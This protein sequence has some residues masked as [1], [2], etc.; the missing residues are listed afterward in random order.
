[1]GPGTAVAR[2]IMSEISS[3]VNSPMDR[4]SDSMTPSMTMPPPMVKAPILKKRTKMDHKRRMKD[5]AP[6]ER[7]G[8]KSPPLQYHQAATQPSVRGSVPPARVPKEVLAMISPRPKGVGSSII[9]TSWPRD[10]RDKAMSA[11][12]PRS[13]C[14]VRPSIHC[15]RGASSASCGFIPKSTRFETTCRCPWGCMKAPITPNG[16]TGWQRDRKSV[17]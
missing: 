5:K 3:S 6:F 17:V 14:T 11:E 8:E 2:T 9:R 15:Q 7:K 10:S 4:T 1:M 13:I 16:P 12:T